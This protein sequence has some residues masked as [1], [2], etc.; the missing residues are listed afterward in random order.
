[1]TFYWRYSCF[2]APAKKSA[3]NACNC[4]GRGYLKTLVELQYIRYND[5]KSIAY[6][7]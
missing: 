1:M 4:G 7:K 3:N 6:L 5:F 2:V